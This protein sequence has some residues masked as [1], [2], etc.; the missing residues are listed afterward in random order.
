MALPHLPA[1]E[2]SQ[3]AAIVIINAAFRVLGND[4]VDD[5]FGDMKHFFCVHKKLQPDLKPFF[6]QFLFMFTIHVRPD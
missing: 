4:V 1:I 3:E 6:I 2:T 5:V